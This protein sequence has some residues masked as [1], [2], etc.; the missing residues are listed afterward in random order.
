MKFVTFYPYKA[1]WYL[2]DSPHPP[3]PLSLNLQSIFF[4]PPL[5]LLETADSPTV[6]A[7]K[8]C[9]PPSPL[10]KKF[11]IRHPWQ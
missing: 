11:F 1:R 3:P 4:S 8:P 10:K 6:P 5:T 2:I 7:W 9:N